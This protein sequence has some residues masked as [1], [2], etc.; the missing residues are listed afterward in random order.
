[1]I[2]SRSRAVRSQRGLVGGGGHRGTRVTDSSAA[3]AGRVFRNSIPPSKQT[4]EQPAR[5]HVWRCTCFGYFYSV[6]RQKPRTCRTSSSGRASDPAPRSHFNHSAVRD[7]AFA[8]PRATSARRTKSSFCCALA[9]RVAYTLMIK[10]CSSSP[11]LL[12]VSRSWWKTT[13][14]FT[15]SSRRSSQPRNIPTRRCA[16]SSQERRRHSFA[17]FRPYSSGQRGRQAHQAWKSTFSPFSSSN[18]MITWPLDGACCL[19]R[20]TSLKL[21]TIPDSPRRTAPG[22]RKSLKW[23]Q[24]SIKVS[25]DQICDLN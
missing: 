2:L 11:L 4:S 14:S 23:P 7:V 5:K 20:S 18:S 22:C 12:A 16:S 21:T 25:M 10:P 13:V 15:R 24:L 3:G 9:S 19:Y 6:G 8:R 1:M 17:F